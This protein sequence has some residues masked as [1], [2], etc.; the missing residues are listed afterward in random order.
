R[1]PGKPGVLP[2]VAAGAQ[3]RLVFLGDACGPLRPV[4]GGGGELA[5]LIAGMAGII[6]QIEL[7]AVAARYAVLDA[8]AI[9]IPADEM[10][11]V[12]EIAAPGR[13]AAGRALVFEPGAVKRLG[14]T[15]G[16]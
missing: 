15:I 10:D 12:A 6:G 7:V 14:I 4:A 2:S 16:A 9:V 13:P 11:G 3:L 8:A 1:A 5:A